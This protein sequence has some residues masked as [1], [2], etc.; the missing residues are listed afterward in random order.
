M[1][2][3]N[4]KLIVDLIMFLVLVNIKVLN[5]KIN[6]VRISKQSNKCWV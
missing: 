1:F 6:G 3:C 2:V 5:T 4:D